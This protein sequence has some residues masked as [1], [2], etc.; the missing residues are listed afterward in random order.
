MPDRGS[1]WVPFV[2]VTAVAL[3][4]L[5]MTLYP[6]PA[7]IPV[8]AEVTRVAISISKDHRTAIVGLRTPTGI[9]EARFVDQF[10]HCEVGD[11]VDAE[12]SGVAVRRGPATCA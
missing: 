12:Q 8:R 2:A 5:L 9:G 4:G 11:I 1:R 6:E 7:W 3:G 10:P